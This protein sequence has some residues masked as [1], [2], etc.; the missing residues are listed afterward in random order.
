VLAGIGVGRSETLP[1]SS[2]LPKSSEPTTS[3]IHSP[4]P[5]TAMTPKMPVRPIIR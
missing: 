1:P 4:P 5:I 3:R 2:F